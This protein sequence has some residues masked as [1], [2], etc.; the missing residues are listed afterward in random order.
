MTF[1]KKLRLILMMPILFSFAILPNV[2]P[3]Y[4]A[5][6]CDSGGKCLGTQELD[7]TV[8]FDQSGIK[9]LVDIPNITTSS[10]CAP[11]GNG[12]G[13]V[14]TWA[15]FA[16]GEWIG[17]GVASGQIDGICYDSEEHYYLEYMQDFDVNEFK[18]SGSPSPGEDIY[19]QVSDTNNDDTWQAYVDTSQ[20]ASLIMDFDYAS[21]T[22]TGV[23]A[24]DNNI[25]VPKTSIT[26]VQEHDGTDWDYWTYNDR[27][28]DQQEGWI[29]QCTP[30]YK[31]IAVGVGGTESC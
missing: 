5:E 30:N 16:N 10:T 13:V 20:A 23:E 11:N 6:N 29:V 2:H 9:A 25:S 7:S 8:S 1:T 19:F 18:L 4:G 27:E 14:S 24:T 17:I 28:Y 21:E 12:F 26:N 22:S 3:A 15:F 31:N